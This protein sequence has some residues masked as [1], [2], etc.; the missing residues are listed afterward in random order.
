MYKEYID[1]IIDSYEP[2]S[3]NEVKKSLNL[4]I[5]SHLKQTTDPVDETIPH[6]LSGVSW[7]WL[8]RVAIRG[9]FKGRQ[10]NYLNVEATKRR[11][12]LGITLE[13]AMKQYGR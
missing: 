9:D 6:P 8:C 11:E 10:S 5:K 4:Y 1:V 12:Q 2:E 3:K 7:Q 13:Q